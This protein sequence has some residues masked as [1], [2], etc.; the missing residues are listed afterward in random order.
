[1]DKTGKKILQLQGYFF[2]CIIYLVIGLLMGTELPPFILLLLYGLSFFF[3]NVGPNTTAFLLPSSTFEPEVRSTMN[4]IS[5]AGGKFGAV[6]GTFVLP[7]IQDQYGSAVI[8]YICS[9][10]ALLGFLLTYFFV[11]NDYTFSCKKNKEEPL[12][13]ADAESVTQPILEQQ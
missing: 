10:C 1:M 8:M 12:I 7:I 2:V 9:G 6:L 5:A 11:D 4:G 3:L 13:Q